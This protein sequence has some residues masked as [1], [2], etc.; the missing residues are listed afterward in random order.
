MADE[1]LILSFEVENQAVIKAERSTLDFYN[2]N[3][4]HLR[5]CVCVHD[6]MHAHP[7]YVGGGRHFAF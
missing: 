4:A 1:L 6:G 2:A 7:G 3:E 5:V